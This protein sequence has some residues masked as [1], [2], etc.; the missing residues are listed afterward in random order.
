MA[1]G[2]PT[3]EAAKRH[4]AQRLQNDP[5]TIEVPEWELTVHV[6]PATLEERARYIETEGL[7]RAVDLVIVR[8]KHEDG[9]PVFQPGERSTLLRRV[10]PDVLLR[11]AAEILEGDNEPSPRE[12]AED[13]DESPASD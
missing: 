6:W 5:R 8:A 7:E 2:N 4:W 3:L 9:T 13:F 10:D 11:L 12:V 1:G